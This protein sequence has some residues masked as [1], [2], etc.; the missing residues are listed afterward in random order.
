M[1]NQKNDLN[2]YSLSRHW[3]DF[4]FE[5]PEKIRPNHTALYFFAI[6]HC[7]RLGWKRKFGFP[8]TMAM[9][10]IGIHSYNTYKKT[11]DEVIGFGFIKMIE[12]SKNQY[13]SNVIA[14]SNFEKAPDK[15]LDKALAKHG[16]KQL[17]STGQ[18]K[19]SI[20][21]QETIEPLNKEQENSARK[22]IRKILN[23]IS[24][25]ALSR[26]LFKIPDFNDVFLDYWLS[27]K[28][29]YDQWPGDATVNECYRRLSE[30]LQQGHDPVA[31][32]RQSIQAGNKA[33]YEVKDSVYDSSKKEGHTQ[34][35]YLTRML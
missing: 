34:Y 35:Q 25:P 29:N 28:E 3:F 33:L 6:E 23:G 16:S 9:E 19:C 22:N 27:R 5:N 26:P 21:K 1:S 32:L 14:L 12:K 31:V 7:N 15:A 17:K 13:S 11:L 10:A 30:L 2:G 24:R 8:T 20:Y 18:S 4:C